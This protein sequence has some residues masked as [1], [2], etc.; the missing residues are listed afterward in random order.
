MIVLQLSVVLEILL[1]TWHQ[2]ASCNQVIRYASYRELRS[3]S[4]VQE[5]F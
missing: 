5:H 3:S 1:L 2:N 4:R